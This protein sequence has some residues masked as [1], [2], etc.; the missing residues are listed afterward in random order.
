MNI[1]KKST[2]QTLKIALIVYAGYFLFE[3]L[4]KNHSFQ[5]RTWLNGIINEVTVSRIIAYT[6]FTI[7]MILSVGVIHKFKDMWSALGLNN[8]LLKGL[9]VSF[10]GTLPMLI[11]FAFTFN[12]NTEISAHWIIYG[13][14]VA[15]FFEELI[16]RGILFGQI[17][18]YTKIGFIP[19]ILLVSVIFGVA[20]VY[21]SQDFSTIIGIFFTT[22]LGS[23]LFAWL[24]VE[25]NYN[26][27]VAVFLHLFMNLY[28]ILFSVSDH[29][30]GSLTSNIFR[31]VS[32]LLMVGITIFYKK[33]KGLNFEVNRKTLWVNNIKQVI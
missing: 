29:A 18:R 26:L 6:L 4:F 14:I 10:L 25:W 7:P 28:W 16:F 31:I 15:A 8:S 12:F 9:A 3:Y 27:W 19:T 17:F 32:I 1:E 21:Q 11:G 24:F 20:H 22:F 30:L 2:I 33:R 5:F 13:S 23:A